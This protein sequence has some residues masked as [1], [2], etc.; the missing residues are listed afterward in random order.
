MLRETESFE[1][2]ADRCKNGNGSPFPF[3]HIKL[4]ENNEAKQRSYCRCSIKGRSNEK[5]CAFSACK[6]IYAL[7]M[8]NVQPFKGK[9]FVNLHF[10]DNLL[11]E[12]IRIVHKLC[13]TMG[14]NINNKKKCTCAD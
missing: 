7:C 1:G 5:D 4:K 12:N 13:C 2:S 14:Y 3:L 10:R 11:R 8:L 9:I 6:Y